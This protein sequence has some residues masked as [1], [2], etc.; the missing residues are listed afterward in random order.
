M[1][2]IPILESMQDE[3]GRLPY[4]T[5]AEAARRA[6]VTEKQAKWAWQRRPGPMTPDR[7]FAAGV[8]AR[9]NRAIPRDCPF[10]DREL[11]EAWFAGWEAGN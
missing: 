7:A 2:P 3:L 5:Y 9:D 1:N 11:R 8:E 6:G 10:W 4:G